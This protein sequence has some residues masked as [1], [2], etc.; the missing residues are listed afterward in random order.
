VA[1]GVTAAYCAGRLPTGVGW[2]IMQTAGGPPKAIDRT[3]VAADGPKKRSLN[4]PGFMQRRDRPH[5]GE[6]IQLLLSQGKLRRKKSSRA[7]GPD[8]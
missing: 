4:E 5:G 2:L 7:T 1:D 8:C 6:L 3:Q